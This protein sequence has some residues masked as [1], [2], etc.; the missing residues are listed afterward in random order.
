MKRKGFSRG[1]VQS[2]QTGYPRKRA[3]TKKR[4]AATNKK[5]VTRAKRAVRKVITN[6]LNDAKP[7]NMYVTGNHVLMGQDSSSYYYPDSLLCWDVLDPI[8][9]ENA[10]D[11]LADAGG[12]ISQ[13]DTRKM[14]LKNFRRAGSSIIARGVRIDYQFYASPDESVLPGNASDRV[15]DTGLCIKMMLVMDKKY[16]H[17]NVIPGVD[18][19]SKAGTFKESAGGS[20][21]NHTGGTLDI[22][23][24]AVGFHE[25]DKF[26]TRYQKIDKGINTRRY[27]VLRTWKFRMT[28]KYQRH[29]PTKQGHVYYSLRDKKVTYQAVQDP[30]E[31]AGSKLTD[32][33]GVAVFSKPNLKIIMFYENYDGS[34][35]NGSET[36]MGVT[37]GKPPLRMRVK[38]TTY[39]KEELNS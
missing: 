7:T 10:E 20:V 22:L 31:S 2:K 28:R 29:R 15:L 9:Y 14:D 21:D 35:F 33:G 37:A 19:F 5:T 30:S 34:F 38:S 3:R 27:H 12:G 13:F 8:K 4:G 1:F 36:N 23:D 32:S 6:T 17:D 24:S 11:T 16:L 25:N 26:M 18:M 39:W